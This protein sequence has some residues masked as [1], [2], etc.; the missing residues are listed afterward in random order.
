MRARTIVALLA[1]VVV[2]TCGTPPGTAT[3]DV[4]SPGTLLFTRSLGNFDPDLSSTASSATYIR[5]WSTSPAS[6][7]DQ[8]L[9]WV[10]DLFAGT[11]FDSTCPR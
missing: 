9:H 8:W 2:G 1:A 4:E 10:G 3:A 7:S 11:P 5:Y 6:A